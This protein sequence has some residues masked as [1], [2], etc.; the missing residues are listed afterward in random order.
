MAYKTFS[1]EEI[2]AIGFDAMA[3]AAFAGGESC[4]QYLAGIAHGI[5]AVVEKFEEV[6]GVDESV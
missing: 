4:D 2:K 5:L 6:V 3:E 1:K